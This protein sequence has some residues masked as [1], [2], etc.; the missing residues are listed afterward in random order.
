MSETERAAFARSFSGYYDGQTPLTNGEMG[1]RWE[2]YDR[3]EGHGIKY[4]DWLAS[5][6]ERGALKTKP[7]E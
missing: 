3:T 5:E 2:E 7:A 4:R 1:R 6:R